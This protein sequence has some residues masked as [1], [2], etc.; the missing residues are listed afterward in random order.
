MHN[1]DQYF[2]GVPEFH[3]LFMDQAWDNLA[4]RLEGLAINPE[5]II[6]FG[7]GSGLG[8]IAMARMWPQAR[9]WAV[10]PDQAMRTVLMGRLGSDREL[11]ER[12][13]VVPLP[14]GPDAAPQLDALLP[15]S[16]DL[17]IAPHMVGILDADARAML[18]SL[19][20]AHIDTDGLVVATV[21]TPHRDDD[22]D[23]QPKRFMSSVSVGDHVV[24]LHMIRDDTGQTR[25]TYT[26]RT[27]DGT[28][29]REVVGGPRTPRPV[30]TNGNLIEPDHLAEATA[31]GLTVSIDDSGF[32]TA[33]Q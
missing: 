2:H 1:D 8:I 11:R 6:E 24:D 19:A 3:E 9:F 32:L 23:L 14:V 30:D 22:D 17:V 10:E 12:V 21:G 18:W 26:Q 4:E 16:A 33:R 7:A 31:A 27:A 20:R 28:V 15:A 25:A 5:T 13:T 29:V